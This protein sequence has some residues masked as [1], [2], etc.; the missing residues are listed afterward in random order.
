M[1]NLRLFYIY[2]NFTRDVYILPIKYDESLS[3]YVCK[4]FGFNK[5]TGEVS[6]LG[7]KYYRK[8]GTC[9]NF[10]NNNATVIV[11]LSILHP[12][13]QKTIK[14]YKTYIKKELKKGEH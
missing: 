7:Y 11:A 9:T 4:L 10:F 5:N 14:N 6:D 2:T 12:K 1:E 8:N 13:L 3:W